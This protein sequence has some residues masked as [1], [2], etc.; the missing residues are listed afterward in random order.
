MSSELTWE[1]IAAFIARQGPFISASTEVTDLHTHFRFGPGVQIDK[2]THAISMAFPLSAAVIDEIEDHPTL[3]YKHHY[4]QVNM[5][6]DRTA[7]HVAAF[8]QSKGGSALPVPASVY[9][10]WKTQAAHL[11]HKMIAVRAGIG[12]IGRHLLLVTPEW[13]ARVRLVTVLTDV[14]IE[15]PPRPRGECGDCKRCLNVCPVS[16]INEGPEDFDLLACNNQ[17]RYFERHGMSVRICGICVKA[18]RPG[19]GKIIE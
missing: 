19:S 3:L 18:C 17:N 6:L 12:W 8:V 15:S 9:I 13:G 5:L 4:R 1:E 16:A 7:T 14:P 2:F 11:S 10:D